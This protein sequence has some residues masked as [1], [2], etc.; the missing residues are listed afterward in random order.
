[1]WHGFRAS[2]QGCTARAVSRTPAHAEARRAR[3]LTAGYRVV[4]AKTG[5]SHQQVKAAAPLDRVGS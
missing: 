5:V 3:V 2:C 1:M 4:L